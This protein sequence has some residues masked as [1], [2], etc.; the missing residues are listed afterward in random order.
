VAGCSQRPWESLIGWTEFLKTKM[1]KTI[2]TL[3]IA[4]CAMAFLNSAALAETKK[5][6]CCEK[7]IADSKECKNKCCL[8]AHKNGKSCEKCN[9]NEEDLKAMKKAKKKTG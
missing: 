6:T 9:P 7:A 3:I 2:K 8:A 5:L 1:M 4:A